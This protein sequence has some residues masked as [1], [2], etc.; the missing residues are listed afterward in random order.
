MVKRLSR[1]AQIEYDVNLSEVYVS[2]RLR[3]R[4]HAAT[5]FS[6]STFD[7]KVPDDWITEHHKSLLSLPPASPLLKACRSQLEAFEMIRGEIAKRWVMPLKC[8]AT[9]LIPVDAERPTPDQWKDENLAHIN[10]CLDEV[11]YY[12]RTAGVISSPPGFYERV[13]QDIE[14]RCM[15]LESCIQALYRQIRELEDQRQQLEAQCR[16]RFQSRCRELA[17]EEFL[18]QVTTD[19]LSLTRQEKYSEREYVLY[20]G[21]VWECDRPLQPDQWRILSDAFL[22]REESEL[23]IA[24]GLQ[25]R[26]QD[27]RE[28][29]P[30]AVRRAVWARDNGRC[31]QCGSRER[32]EYDHIIPIS[33]GGSNTERNIELLCEACNRAKSDAIA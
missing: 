19:P 10:H 3:V 25:Q 5:F 9:A 24:L 31:V 14:T 29:V 26:Q 7:R 15:P 22:A 16:E 21:V 32:L 8:P 30:T 12:K 6:S 11:A 20:R 27:N 2:V 13:R 1:K 17:N 18:T 28:G 33:K 4:T 23:A